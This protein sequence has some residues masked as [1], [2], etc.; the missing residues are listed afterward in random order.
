MVANTVP[1]FVLTSANTV[2]DIENGDGTTL[3]DLITGGTDGTK[4]FAINVTSTD[5]S[6]VELQLHYL[7]S[8][9]AATLLGTVDIATL[10]GTDGAEAAVNLLEHA[11]IACTDA[12]GEMFIG[13]GD[14]LQLAP[15][16]AVT[17][18][19]KVAVFCHAGD[20]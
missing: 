9:G 19:T 11:Q 13:N 20:Y 1:I 8:G 17:A 18:A 16:A 3:Q 15:K 7:P 5:T 12:D 14:K 10:A 2:L 6:T 4:V